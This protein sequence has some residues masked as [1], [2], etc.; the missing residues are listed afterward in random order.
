VPCGIDGVVMTSIAREIGVA[1][2]P[3]QDVRDRITAAFAAAFDLTAVVTSR[4]A[5]LETVA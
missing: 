1:D 5:L 2:I 4:S 3:I